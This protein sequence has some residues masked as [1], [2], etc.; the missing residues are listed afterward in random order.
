MLGKQPSR[1]LLNIN[2]KQKDLKS[3]FSKIENDYFLGF[4]AK[5]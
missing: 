1:S 5:K 4:R 2:R 3:E